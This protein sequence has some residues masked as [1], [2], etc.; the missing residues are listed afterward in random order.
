MN[1]RM[2]N[3]HPMIKLW[4]EYEEPLNSFSIPLLISAAKHHSS[5]LCSEM[6]KYY[7]KTRTYQK[8]YQ[9]RTTGEKFNLENRGGLSSID[10]AFDVRDYP[11]LTYNATR[12]CCNTAHNKIA[13]LTPKVTLLTKGGSRESIDFSQ[14]VEKWIFKIF[15][16]KTVY[17]KSARAFLD[18]VVSGLGVIKLVIE[19]DSINFEKVNS[20]DFFCNHA[21]TGANEPDCAGEK[22]FLSIYEL[23]EAF[24]SKK[25]E[26]SMFYEDYSQKILVTE[27]Y[28]AKK[29]KI[30]FSEKILFL[31]EKY[32][33]DFVPYEFF[34]W[35]EATEGTISVGISEETYYLQQSITYI[36]MKI[37][38]AL[39]R[40]A[41]TRLYTTKG[42]NPE[43]LSNVDGEIIELNQGEKPP[44]TDQ[45]PP[46]NDAVRVILADFWDKCF[47]VTGLSKM[48][49]YGTMPAGL[50]QAS[51]A[52]LRAYNQIDSERFQLIR[53]NYEENF[54]SLAKKMI[55]MSPDSKL[56]KGITRKDVNE[57]IHNITIFSS[58]ILPETPS[59]RYA[60]LSD[61]MN[62]GFVSREQALSLLKSPDMDKFQSSESSR[63]DAIQK[64]IETS[65]KEN[66]T[67][68]YY[69]ELGLEQTFDSA[70]KYFAKYVI[71]DDEDKLALLRPFITT[72][73]QKVTAQTQLNQIPNPNE[74]NGAGGES[75]KPQTFSALTQPNR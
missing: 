54:V 61:M 41:T 71:E 27:M 11:I 74:M 57:N 5:L 7:Q 20:F 3:N 53:E 49:A 43:K 69:P 30:I 36:V 33:Y 22:R 45:P 40:I 35:S 50:Q 70:R 72:L 55:K 2:I 9:H 34:K 67:P 4:Y 18:A 15:K 23:M 21:M 25:E 59:G 8:N 66:R 13:K 65:L 60:I 24:P 48:D 62:S 56:P 52:A 47:E 19:K 73:E 6:Q 28:K 44:V 68:T 38:K 63:I 17:K 58:N 32:D 10:Q 75:R 39:H 37:M 42:S 31:F 14:K 1:H 16:K 26:L 46:V 64:T 51:G 12:A 29:R